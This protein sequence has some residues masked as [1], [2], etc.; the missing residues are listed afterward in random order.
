MDLRRA[1]QRVVIGCS[2]SDSGLLKFIHI[3]DVVKLSLA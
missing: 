2:S 1:F 3:R